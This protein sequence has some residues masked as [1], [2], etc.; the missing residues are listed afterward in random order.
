VP[1]TFPSHA[2]GI[3]TLKV[4]WPRWIDGV[5]LVVGAA[6]PDLAYVAGCCSPPQTYGHSWWGTIV[7]VP[8]TL[9]VGWLIRWAAPVVATHVPP[10][11]SLALR[12]YGVLGLVHHRWWI[13]A[14]S[15]WIGAFSHVLWDHVTHTSIAGTDLGLPVLN[16]ELVGGVPWWMPIHLLSSVLGALAWLAITVHIGRRRLLIQWHGPAPVLPRRPK[17]F[18]GVFA[19]TGLGGSLVVSVLTWLGNREMMVPFLAPVPRPSVLVVRA[20]TVLCLAALVAAVAVQV[21]IRRSGRPTAGHLPVV[22]G[23]PTAPTVGSASVAEGETTASGP[24]EGG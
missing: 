1:A 24:A 23:R 19:A 8:F 11:G 6:M 15:A 12:D 10:L 5:A 16:A 18:W 2:G 4:F 14:F 22:T 9:A 3:L 21:S 17:V 7:A 20:G 13:S